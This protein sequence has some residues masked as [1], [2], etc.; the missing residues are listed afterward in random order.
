MHPTRVRQ[1]ELHDALIGHCRELI[2][3]DGDALSDEAVDALR[4]SAEEMARVLISVFL[5][6]SGQAK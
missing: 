3:K 4:R 1:H 6:K 2:G 5:A